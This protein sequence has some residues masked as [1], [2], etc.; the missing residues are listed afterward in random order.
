M[1]RPISSLLSFYYY[2][3]VALMS[4]LC[5]RFCIC[6]TCRISRRQSASQADVARTWRTGFVCEVRKDGGKQTVHLR[7]ENT[8][9]FFPT[10]AFSGAGVYFFRL[11]RILLSFPHLGKTHKRCYAHW[12]VFSCF[13]FLPPDISLSKCPI[14]DTIPNDLVEDSSSPSQ[15]RL[16]MSSFV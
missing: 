11:I 1:I 15:T 12:H 3:L 16:N 5:S 14:L 4:V 2:Y 9:F 7:G 10:V 13:F 8:F 6:V